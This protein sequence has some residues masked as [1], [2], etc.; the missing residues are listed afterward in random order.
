MI[1]AAPR[2]ILRIIKKWWVTKVRNLPAR[3]AFSMSVTNTVPNS[4]AKKM[5]NCEALEYP[6]LS[7]ARLVVPTQKT[8]TL[9]L[10]PL[11]I[12]PLIK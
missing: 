6:K 7:V 4:A 5:I 3:Y 10:S 1:R 11:M 12:N 8:K 9:G 2:P